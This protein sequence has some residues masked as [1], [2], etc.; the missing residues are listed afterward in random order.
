MFQSQLNIDNSSWDWWLSLSLS[1]TLTL[2]SLIVFLFVYKSNSVLA[3]PP[4]SSNRG[5]KMDFT[6]CLKLHF[7]RVD[8]YGW[9]QC[10]SVHRCWCCHFSLSIISRAGGLSL[11]SAAL[12]SLPLKAFMLWSQR[13]ERDLLIMWVRVLWHRKSATQAPHTVSRHAALLDSHF[14]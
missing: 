6:V 14:D 4:Y 12:C 1:L 5:D 8:G 10:V 3:A 9:V 11:M 13:Y 7:S 2:P